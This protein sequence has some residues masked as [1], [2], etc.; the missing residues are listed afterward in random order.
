MAYASFE[1]Y[2]D[3]YRGRAITDEEE[4]DRLEIRAEAVLNRLTFGRAPRYR[5]SGGKLCLACCAVTEKLARME[6]EDAMGDRLA[7][8]QVGDYVRRTGHHVLYRVT[9]RFEGDN[10]VASGVEME[11]RSIE[12]EGKGVCFHVFVYNVQPGVK[13]NYRDG[14]SKSD[15]KYVPAPTAASAAE[16]ISEADTIS[17]GDWDAELPVDY[18]TEDL[19]HVIP[20]PTFILNTN[21]LRFHKPWCKSV[22][23]IKEKNRQEFFGTREEL[24]EEGYTPCSICNP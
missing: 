24:I 11:A 23:D 6:E 12:D 8:E 21:T 19:D 3:L 1:Q 5:D 18:N 4:F 15:P 9:P 16:D 22:A 14:S 10:L 7:E 13:I 17:Q 20:E 2:R